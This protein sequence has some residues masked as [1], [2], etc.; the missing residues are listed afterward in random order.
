MLGMVTDW[1][2]WLIGA[3]ALGVIGNLITKLFESYI[4]K[5]NSNRRKKL[6]TRKTR[7]YN[8]LVFHKAN[9]SLMYLF[10]FRLFLVLALV[11]MFQGAVAMVFSVFSGMHLLLQFPPE[12]DPLP[13]FMIDYKTW[14]RISP[15]VILLITIA[16]CGYMFANALYRVRY[17]LRFVM[18]PNRFRHEVLDELRRLD[19][20][21]DEKVLLKD[22]R[23][24]SHKSYRTEG[25]IMS[26]PVTEPDETKKQNNEAQD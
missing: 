12:D 13:R 23:N 15:L 24:R 20:G 2:L 4:A 11:V 5:Y 8:Q 7:N 14:F 9:G 26:A 25:V 16:Y 17:I 1:S 6:I 19:P 21:I 3:L 18:S 22:R 10:I